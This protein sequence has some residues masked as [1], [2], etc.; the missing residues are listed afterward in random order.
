MGKNTGNK[1]I[2]IDDYTMKRMAIMSIPIFIELFLQLLVG[3]VDQ[4][5]ISRYSQEAVAAIGNGNQIMKNLIPG[6]KQQKK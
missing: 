4:I 5:M 6:V 3:N 2:N 1:D